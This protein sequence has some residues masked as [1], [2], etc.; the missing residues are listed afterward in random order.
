MHGI[1]EEG[2]TFLGI[3][4][5]I[6]DKISLGIESGRGMLSASWPDRKQREDRCSA[7]HNFLFFL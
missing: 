4:P 7:T 6:L 5:L 3:G 1:A 2:V